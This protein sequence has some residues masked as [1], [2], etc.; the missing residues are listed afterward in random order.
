MPGM[1][2]PVRVIRNSGRATLSMALSENAGAVK[3]GV[4]SCKR[5]PDSSTCPRISKKPSPSSR[6]PTTA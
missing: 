5:S 2:W 4:A 6:M 1:Y 3:T